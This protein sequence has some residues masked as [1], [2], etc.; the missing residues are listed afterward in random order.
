[1]N[2]EQPAQSNVIDTTDC[3]EAVETFKWWKNALFIIVLLCYLLIQVSFWLVDRGLVRTE[4]SA[5]AQLAQQF[6]GSTAESGSQKQ[7]PQPS[8]KQPVE[9]KMAVQTVVV[10]SSEPNQ[11][12]KADV[13]KQAEK[14][15]FTFEITYKQL[16]GAVRFFNFILIP[17][18]MLYCLVMLFAMKVSILGRLGGI[19][20]IAKA[21][22]LSLVFFIFLAPWQIVY[23]GT[24]GGVMFTAAELVN[25]YQI[26]QSGSLASRIP[27]Y[28]RYVVYWLI[29]MFPL[30][31]AQIR[32][33]R[34][35]KAV[36]RRLE[37]MV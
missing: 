13:E 14:K 30:I 9:T 28:G 20:H 27:Y 24:T 2:D 37:I 31:L 29:V 33:I 7:L 25:R 26:V 6:L 12:I 22:F 15:T 19:N 17:A 35:S 8:Q 16:N 36:L 21:F 18:S 10:V 23:G 4:Q 3:L 1:M 5:K 34:W 32:S 11:P